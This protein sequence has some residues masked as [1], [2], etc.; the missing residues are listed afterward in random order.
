MGIKNPIPTKNAERIVSKARN[1]LVKE[2]IRCT[3]NKISN[4]EEQLA[5]KRSGFKQRFPLDTETERIM[6]EHLQREHEKEFKTTKYR[7]TR[8]LEKLT[9]AK[10]EDEHTEKRKKWVCNLSQRKLTVTESSVLSRGLNFATTPI[11]IPYEEFIVAT[12][13]ACQNITNQGDK[14]GLRNAIAG[15]LKSARDYTQEHKQGR[16]EG[17]TV[18]SQRQNH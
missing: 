8:K 11:N 16:M 7:H 14:A 17:Y 15:I 1:A 6:N 13:L 2:R 9:S 10:K 12:E 4:I 5:E 18:N 3:V